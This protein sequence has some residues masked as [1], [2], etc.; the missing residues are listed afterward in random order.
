MSITEETLPPSVHPSSTQVNV[1]SSPLFLMRSVFRSW[2]IVPPDGKKLQLHLWRN[3]REYRSAEP[4]PVWTWNL[5]LLCDLC[6]VC[7]LA[8]DGIKVRWVYPTEIWKCLKLVLNNNILVA[9][10]E[11]NSHCPYDNGIRTN[12]HKEIWTWLELFAISKKS[13]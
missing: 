7:C 1:L 13:W 6:H 2:P 10:L 9:H 4:E 5:L 3:S 11:K 12:S 8:S